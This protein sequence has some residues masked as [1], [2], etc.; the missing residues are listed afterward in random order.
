MKYLL[1]TNTCIFLMKN[2]EAVVA[3]YKANKKCGI[4][5]SSIT[6]AEL[7]F[8]VYN[9]AS[10]EKNGENL[11]NFLLG[12]NIVD[13]DS[14]AASEYGR[15]RSALQKKGTLIGQFDM[16][17]AA[18]AKS[19]GLIAVTNN[20]REFERVEGLMLEDWYEGR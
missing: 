5:I 7:Y 1:D 2:R 15:V 14:T 16:L 11:T 20:T 10:P 17:I 4:A 12:F 9:S 19:L 13:F 8:G 3:R 18:H 6:V